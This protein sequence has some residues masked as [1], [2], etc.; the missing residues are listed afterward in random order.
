MYV[1]LFHYVYEG[2][3]TERG[4]HKVVTSFMLSQEQIKMLEDDF[5]KCYEVISN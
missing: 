4:I 5:W 3:D 1:Y 2:V